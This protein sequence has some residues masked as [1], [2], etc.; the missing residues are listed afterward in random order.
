M[1]LTKTVKIK[2]GSSNRK[3]LESKGYVFTKKGDEFEVK[4][5]DLSDGSTYLVDVLCDY[6]LEEGIETHISR[7]YKRY[8]ELNRDAII[9]KDCCR[10]CQSK[11]SAESMMKTYGVSHTNK[12]D[13]YK[14][15][16]ANLFREDEENIREELLTYDLV[17]VGKYVNANTP[18]DCICLKHP[19]G[20]L[21]KIRLANLRFYDSGCKLCGL[22]KRSQNVI[23]KTNITDV[24]QEFEDR[25][26]ILLEEEYNGSRIPLK[27]ICRKH[28]NEIQEVTLTAFRLGVGC[29]ECS[30]ENHKGKNAP[31]WKGGIS[32][33][34]QHLRGVILPWK[35]DSMRNCDYKC[36]ITG[37]KFD[38][39]HHLYGF[40]NIMLESLDELNLPLYPEVKDYS[41]EE[42]KLL[43]EKVL[44]VHYRYPLGVCV[45]NDIHKKFH[46]IYGNGDNTS[47]QW[48]EFVDK[49]LYE[50]V[51]A[52]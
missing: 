25:D 19:N 36:V 30:I 31:N 43:E 48:Q 5:E 20:K 45:C 52:S 22:E 27:F 6:C 8:L 40:N 42:M 47:E 49:K 26:L 33:L 17:L 44:E 37:G 10:K 34:S 18:V 46:S 23:S 28:P 51:I 39:I 15:N 13:K 50:E 11:K 32:K 3:H 41:D 29:K 9:H 21:Q 35:K 4:V 1:L 12:L 24:K 38:N 7:I 2:W 14:D 16:L